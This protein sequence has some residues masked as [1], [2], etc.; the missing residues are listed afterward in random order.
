MALSTLIYLDDL[1]G[2]RIIEQGSSADK[3]SMLRQVNQAAVFRVETVKTYA[4]VRRLR[5]YDWW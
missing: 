3:L 1:S 2:Y 4:T 5:Y